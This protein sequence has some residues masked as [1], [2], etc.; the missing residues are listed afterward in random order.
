MMKPFYRCL[1]DEEYVILHEKKLGKVQTQKRSNK[2]TAND[3]LSV[4]DITA[5][6]GACHASRER[7]F[8]S[9][10]YE[11]GFRIGEI[12]QMVWNDIKFDAPGAVVNLNFKTGIN[13]YIRLVMAREYLIKWKS[14]YPGSP[15]GENL[16]FIS[17]HGISPTRAAL[18]KT[19]LFLPS[20]QEW[21][22][23]SLRIY[24]DIPTLPTSFSKA[25][26]NRLSNS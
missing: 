22:N 26:T 25:S 14:D 6:L 17:D 15:S 4:D 24:S 20:V 23:I 1:I 21:R 19:T 11:G 16:V 18:N 8:I 13:R 9:T 5:I 3:L 12:G 7:A 2:R 10:L